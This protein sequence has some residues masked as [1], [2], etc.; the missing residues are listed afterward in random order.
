MVSLDAYPAAF[1]GAVQ[2]PSNPGTGIFTPAG[3]GKSSRRWVGSRIQDNGN[4]WQDFASITGLKKLSPDKIPPFVTRGVLL[5]MAAFYGVDMVKEGTAFNEAE[6]EGA[7]KKQ[8]IEIR[9]GDVVFFHT[10]WLSIIEKDPKRFSA[11][12]PGLGREGARYL[13]SKNVVTVGA[14]TWGLEVI[15]FEQGA[16]V[17]EIHQILLPMSGTWPV[18]NKPA[19]AVT[20]GKAR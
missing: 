2:L 9:Q 14:D 5:N 13:V 1:S 16:G 7:A 4:K 8:G 10:G 15:P 20:P 19:T 6:I 12:E 11:A 18:C 3:I 17:F